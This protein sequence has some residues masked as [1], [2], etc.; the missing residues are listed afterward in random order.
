MDSYTSILDLTVAIPGACTLGSFEKHVHLG[1][2]ASS[3][4]SQS[5]RMIAPPI[6]GL[7]ADA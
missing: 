5:T 2:M 1:G 7:C 4:I 3:C 6:E